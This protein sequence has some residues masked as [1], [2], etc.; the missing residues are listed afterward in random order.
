MNL[1]KSYELQVYA[2]GNW[3]VLAIFDD[4]RLSEVEARVIRRTRR[5]VAIRIREEIYDNALAS[6]RSRL[7]YHFSQTQQKPPPF[8]GFSFSRGDKASSRSPDRDGLFAG[9][10]QWL[11]TP[12]TISEKLDRLFKLLF[13]G[14][15]LG[16]MAIIVL[17]MHFFWHQH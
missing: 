6:Y 2:S 1:D 17:W 10:A 14:V 7:I 9:V 13:L 11:R 12:L 15:C 3:K 16:N 4:R 5:Y 8:D